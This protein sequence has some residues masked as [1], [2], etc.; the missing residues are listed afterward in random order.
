[1][2]PF[3]VVDRPGSLEIL[4]GVFFE[5]PRL[6]FG[7]MTHSN[8]SPNFVKIFREF[9]HKTTLKYFSPKDNLSEESLNNIIQRNI[10]KMSDSG[11]FQKN[12]IS[13]PYEKL[14]EKYVDLKVEFGIIKDVLHNMEKTLKSA[15]E[16]FN[17]YEDNG[18]NKKFKL[19]GVAQGRNIEEYVTCYGELLNM[20]YNYIAI[21]GLLKRNGDSNYVKVRSE[22]FLKDVITAIKE[23]YAPEW[24]F[25]LGV[26]HP[27]RHKILKELGVW[28]ADYKG[29]L[30]HYDE[31]YKT[32][33]EEF[34]RYKDV[35][36]AYKKFL[37]YKTA[38]R[39]ERSK[40][41]RQ[42]FLRA[43][44]ELDNVLKRYGTSLQELRFREIRKRIIH[45][46][47]RKNSL[48]Y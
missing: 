22:Q 30:F 44:K 15:E 31:Y 47:I 1:M 32:S 26:Y 33:I 7:L 4:K 39:K 20:G 37:K 46:I 25:V 12:G 18:F 21:G 2:I 24:I 5:F 43:K 23:E 16:A 9:P 17:V 48:V 13:L 8:V 29:W 11:A 14:F 3:F 19:V 38:Y 34:L 40:N 35:K 6:R 28:G 27:K 41:A 36:V 42:E 10:I 45:E